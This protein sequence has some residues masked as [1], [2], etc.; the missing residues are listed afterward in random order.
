MTD[1]PFQLSAKIRAKLKQKHQ[2]EPQ[3]VA[4]CFYNRTGS[5]LIDT[6]ENHKTD[7]P[8][9]WFVA[10]TDKGRA[11]KIIFIMDAGV[12]HIKSSFDAD[13]QSIRIYKLKAK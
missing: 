3:E 8:T 4:E 6:R 2:V 5:T 7:P 9:E 12:I 11:L 1:L 13:K 10:K